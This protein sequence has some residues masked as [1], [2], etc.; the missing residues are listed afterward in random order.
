M[1]LT[2]IVSVP[3]YDDL[4]PPI[5][6]VVS[7]ETVTQLALFLRDLGH[8]SHSDG[9]HGS[10][11]GRRA[12][13]VII[14]RVTLYACVHGEA[15]RT[16]ALLALARDFSPRVVRASDHEILLDVSGLGR[17]IGEPAA[18]AAEID[19]AAC[20]T[21]LRVRV[22]IAPTQTAARLLAGVNVCAA[23]VVVSDAAG[24]LAPLPVASLQPL[25]VLPP[26]INVRDRVRPY[27]IFESWGIATLGD[28]VKLPAAELSSRLGRRGT[29]LHRLARGLDARPFVPDGET[30]RYLE[31]LELEWPIDGLEPLSFVLAR[32]LDPLSAALERADRGAAAVHLD[33]RLTD[34]FTHARVLQL[35]APMRDARV[36]RTLLLLD[37][38]SHPPSAA[39]DIVAIEVDPAPARITQFSLLERALPSPETLSTLTARLSALVGESRVGAPALV[40]THRPGAFEMWRFAPA[41][42]MRDVGKVGAT[43]DVVMRRQRV[44]PAIRVNVERGRP[45]FLSASRRGMPSGAVTEVAGPWRT[46]GGWWCGRDPALKTDLPPQGGSHGADPTLGAHGAPARDRRGAEGSPQATEPG[47]WGGA[48]GPRRARRACEE[49]RGAEG[50][51]QATEPGCGAEPHVSWNRDEWDVALASGAICRIF[52]DRSTGRWFLDGVYD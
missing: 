27:E 47:C 38:E 51:P 7:S 24:A 3:S 21:G 45:V 17:L 13:P 19:R 31:R 37:L 11:K 50:F 10:E 8:G 16:E 20:E 33:L 42:S 49:R 15:E 52:Q 23:N 22:A 48:P 18:I 44:P 36:L 12:D 41:P 29:A 35:P 9:S 46:S 4:T 5:P 14:A 28:L 32:L 34:R 1:E 30:P 6:D 39:V 26:G 40:D 43:G 2:R 25:E